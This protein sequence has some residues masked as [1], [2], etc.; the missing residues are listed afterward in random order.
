MENFDILKD[1]ILP[2][3]VILPISILTIRQL[4]DR[5]V[6]DRIQAEAEKYVEEYFRNTY[7]VDH[8]FVHDFFKRKQK[9]AKLLKEKPILLVFQE[10]VEDH[11][12]LI[13]YLKDRGFEN[14][15]SRTINE[16]L[17]DT[18]SSLIVFVDDDGELSS[19]AID[20]AYEPFAKRSSLF[21]FG[22]GRYQGKHDRSKVTF[23]N[24][25]ATLVSQLENTIL[26]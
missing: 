12:N 3:V 7:G 8:T 14:V 9:E 20:I 6:K 15:D 17:P 24:S 22:G 1:I 16:A 25:R 11:E 18:L 4:I 19:E 2:L 13:K 5:T 10:H 26:S 23:A 21:Y